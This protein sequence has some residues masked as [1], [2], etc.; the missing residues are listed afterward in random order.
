MSSLLER[1]ARGYDGQAGR[2]NQPSTV[3]TS[4]GKPRPA[5]DPVPEWV[6]KAREGKLPAKVTYP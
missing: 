6:Q 4:T 5:H 3:I 1:Y 2:R